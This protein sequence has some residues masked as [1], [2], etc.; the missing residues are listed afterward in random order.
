M[1]K[2]ISF[3]LILAVIAGIVYYCDGGGDPPPDDGSS[4]EQGNSKGLSFTVNGVP[5]IMVKVNGGTFMM[6]ATSEQ[7]NDA[8]DYEKPAHQVTLSDYYIGQTEVTQALWLAV[9]GNNPSYFGFGD[10]YLNCPVEKLSWNDCQTFITKLNKLTG[11]KFRLPTEAEW[12]YAARG[13]KKSKGFKYAGSNNL[14]EVAWSAPQAVRTKAVASKAPNELGL[15][16][17]SGNVREWVQDKFGS[18]SNVPQTNPTGLVVTSQN[19]RLCR[20]GSWNDVARYCRVSK[21]IINDNPSFSGNTIG[22]RLALP[23]D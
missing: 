9:M 6:G 2:F 15:Y 10:K 23:C 4:T 22:L 1:K 12:E 20:G 14:S 17:M 21:R 11:R 13:G 7:V 19:Y 5:F 3:L 16:D 18:Y 8:D